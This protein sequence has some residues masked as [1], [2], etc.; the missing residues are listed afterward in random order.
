MERYGA[1]VQKWRSAF[2][3]FAGALVIT[4]AWMAAVGWRGQ[5]AFADIVTTLLA[6]AA[7]GFGAARARV[8][9]GQPQI[10]WM[11]LCGACLSW[12][13]GNVIWTHAELVQ[14]ATRAP[15]AADLG[16]LMLIPFAAS[17]LLVM[18]VGS[19]TVASRARILLDALLVSTATLFVLYAIGLRP[20]ITHLVDE[21]DRLARA[22]SLA[23]PLGDLFLL[24]LLFLV[25]VR[26]PPATRKA[27]IWLAMALMAIALSNFGA[28][29]AGND[30]PR[31][32]GD[33]GRMGGLLIVIYA[34]LRPITDA[35]LVSA[36]KPGPFLAVGPLIPFVLCIMVAVQL[37]MKFGFLEPF[38]FWAAVILIG[39][40]AARQFF[41]VHENFLL[42]RQ[43]DTALDIVRRHERS[44]TQMLNNITHDMRHHLS[45]AVMHIGMMEHWQDPLTERQRRSLGII[46]RSTDQVTRLASDLSDAVSLQAGRFSVQKE[47]VDLAEIARDAAESLRARAQDRGVELRVDADEPCPVRGDRDRLRQVA[48]NL[49]TNAIRFTPKGMAVRVEA[50]I[51]GRRAQVRVIDPGRGLEPEEAA[52]LFQA[53]SQVHGPGEAREKGGMGL[54]LFIS[55]GIMEE[56]GGTIG[57]ESAG[58]GKGSTFHFE[59]PLAAPDSQAPSTMAATS[60]AEVAVR[61]EGWL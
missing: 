7:V 45:P 9:S 23:Y 17:G 34:A 52:R 37:Q 32:W 57:V 49:I 29:Y 59:L 61:A 8:L 42:R 30:Y 33:A 5:P 14:G 16:Y 46:K 1:S 6:F 31:F 26:V 38:V 39:L 55:R 48:F 53:F 40:L 21:P 47:P 28:W 15:V 60:P 44:R 4:L 22:V 12:G 35:P 36:A 58:R 3:A 20:F 10:A 51:A 27:L 18:V 56:H 50:S 11:M 19:T 43:A 54:G 2:V 25:M 41:N 24:A 13:I